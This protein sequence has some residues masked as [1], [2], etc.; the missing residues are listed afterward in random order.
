MSSFIPDAEKIKCFQA[1]AICFNLNPPLSC[2]SVSPSVSYPKQERNKK[3]SPSLLFTG[4]LFHTYL[5][6]L[7]FS[8][9]SYPLSSVLGPFHLKPAAYQSLLSSYWFTGLLYSLLYIQMVLFTSVAPG[10]QIQSSS[11]SKCIINSYGTKGQIC[12]NFDRNEWKISKVQK[13]NLCLKARV[14]Q[15]YSCRTLP[16]LLPT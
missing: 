5:F 3:T 8:L 9:L 1:D 6:I 4:I 13:K 12:L 10:M 11:N 14:T 16:F 2:I 15:P 7:A